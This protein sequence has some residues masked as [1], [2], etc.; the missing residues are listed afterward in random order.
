MMRTQ[1]YLSRE[2]HAALRR[3]AQRDGVSMT[4][5]LR[6]LIDRH[7]LAKGVDRELE[8]EPYFTFVGIG[9]CEASDVAERHDE[10][11]ARASG[12]ADVR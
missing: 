9:E 12:D 1:V 6:R 8:R 5:A 10:Y 2:Q 3:A 11:L 4:E 7:L